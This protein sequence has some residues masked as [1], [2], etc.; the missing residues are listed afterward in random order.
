MSRGFLA[1]A[2]WGTVV[3]G[4][5]LVVAS[6]MSVSPQDRFEDVPPA[7]VVANVPTVPNAEVV[8]GDK[9]SVEAEPSAPQDAVPDLQATPS[10]AAQPD[11]P[12]AIANPEPQPAPDALATDSLATSA[13][14]TPM[15]EGETAAVPEVQTA[16]ATPQT[17]VDAA[18]AP[19]VPG[20]SAEASV[21]PAPPA[22]IPELPAANAPD[23]AP[24]ADQ[25]MPNA[26]PEMPTAAPEMPTADQ[27]MPNAEPE[28]VVVVPTPAPV[29]EGA[30]PPE[31][32]TQSPALDQTATTAP[33]S[34]RPS[35]G[36][37]G[38]VDGVKTGRLPSI[39]AVPATGATPAAGSITITGASSAPID[40]FAKAFENV[41]KKP[42]FAILLQDTGG[43]DIDREALAAIPFPVSFVIDPMLPDA[44]TAAQIYRAAGQEVLMMASG[45]PEGAQASDLAVSFEVMAKTL[46]EAVAVVDLEQGG[47]Q[48][49][50]VLATQVIALIQD[51][52]RGV[53][54]WDRGLNAASQ[55]ARRDGVPSAVIF[56][57]LDAG[58]ESSPVI[59]RYL[60][61]AAFKA[62]Q[63]GRVVVAGQTRPETV[64]A[65]LEWAVEGR[66]ATV[67][68]A[69]ATAVMTKQ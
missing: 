31:T 38:S 57:A 64:A 13:A 6:Q 19:T 12:S 21:D 56:R 33:D 1:G 53:I 41:E 23:A 44:A 5:G 3:A 24:T 14:P 7:V 47:F 49:N 37:G 15:P 30:L 61:R 51:Q 35:T 28:T 68:I 16:T 40:R 60:D 18:A 34:V 25:A 2:G 58:N 55:V 27:A 42:V 17:T 39:E 26:A 32:A 45:I 65:L 10:P 67:A 46:P 62:A 52:G 54:S 43:P 29:A 63:D 22:P 9:P 36:F 69:P 66:A 11:M 20:Q 50:R 4:V 8:P 48:G 59:R